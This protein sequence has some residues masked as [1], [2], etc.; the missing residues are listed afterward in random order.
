M[1]SYLTNDTSELI[2]ALYLID[3]SKTMLLDGS[4]GDQPYWLIEAIEIYKKE[5][6]GLLKESR[7]L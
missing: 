2:R 7:E 5:T 4:L 1:L 6:L 3:S